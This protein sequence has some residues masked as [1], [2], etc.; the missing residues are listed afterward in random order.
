MHAAARAGTPC[1]ELKALTIPDVT[2]LRVTE[3]PAGVFSAPGLRDPLKTSAFCRI[4]AD[5]HPTR[6]SQIRMEVWMPPA[7]A[8]N[9]KFEGVG[10]GGYQGNIPYAAMATGLQLGYAIAATDTGHAGD[11]LRFGQNHPD[12]VI[13]WSYRAVHLTAEVGKLIV[14]DHYGR[15]AQKAYFVGCSTGGHQALSEAQRF[16]ADYDGI[17]A[18]DPAY[19][20]VHQT[21]AYLWS[22]MATHDEKGL[23]LIG[24]PQLKLLTQAAVRACDAKDGVKDGVI[25]DPE[26]CRFDLNTLVCKAGESADSCLSPPQIAAFEKVYAGT[27]NPRTGAEIFPGWTLGSESTGPNPGQGWGAYILDPKD[28][29]RIDVFRYFV[30]ADPNWDWHTFDFDH[31]MDLADSRIGYMSAIDADLG[32][33][34]DRGNKLLMYTGWADPVAAP[35]DVLK[36]YKAVLGKMGGVDSTMKFFRFFMVPGMAHCTGGPGATTFDAL[37]AL[38]SWV[39][40]GKAPDSIMA[41]HFEDGKVTM[42]RPLC[43]YPQRAVWKGSGD[44]NDATNF[45]CRVAAH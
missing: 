35:M 26:N 41:S 22:W 24:Q 1:E 20:R 42:T 45:S 15:F 14:R 16:P 39:E 32:P 28:P 30:Y 9:G 34:R 8:W 4:E 19:D 7:I 2:V 36:Y 5:L 25:G 37:T 43:P 6:D 38:N 12:K 17:V 21:A 23:S 13:D 33:F 3:V 29:M 11:D 40:D 10:N 18:G 44:T 27:K 31:D